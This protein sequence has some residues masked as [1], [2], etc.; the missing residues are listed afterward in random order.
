[1]SDSEL[2]STHR[3]GWRAACS[4]SAFRHS[5]HP[6]DMPDR[7]ELGHMRTRAYAGRRKHLSRRDVGGVF[8]A[9]YCATDIGRIITQG[10]AGLK[11]SCRRSRVQD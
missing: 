4:T 3:S 9:R 6:A 11:C 2:C 7:S 5:D 1:M 10:V 8:G